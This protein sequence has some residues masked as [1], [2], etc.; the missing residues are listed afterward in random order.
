VTYIIVDCFFVKAPM[1]S[2]QK[3]SVSMMPKLVSRPEFAQD[4]QS[5]L[6]SD[7]APVALWDFSELRFW[8]SSYKFLNLYGSFCP[9]SP[10]Y[11][12]GNDPLSSKMHTGI[13]TRHDK[14]Q[15]K[16]IWCRTPYVLMWK[17]TGPEKFLLY[18]FLGTMGHPSFI[19]K[20]AVNANR[21]KIIS[22]CD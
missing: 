5:G 8:K 14:T 21:S 10:P 7:R 20:H 9:Y 2:N 22:R 1:V 6:R 15:R 3:I 11:K 19:D 17:K 16:S 18:T 13:F 4:H 12:P